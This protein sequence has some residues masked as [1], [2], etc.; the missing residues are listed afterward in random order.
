M[1]PVLFFRMQI[2]G[3]LYGIKSDR[4]ICEEID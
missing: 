4:K 3:Y 2:I 1:D